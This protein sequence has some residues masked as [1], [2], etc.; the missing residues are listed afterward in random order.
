M[1]YFIIG[2][3]LVGMAF[4]DTLFTEIDESIIIVDRYTTP[5]DHW[6]MAYPFVKLH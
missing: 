1:D 5:G 6:N 3:G 4:A 2:Y